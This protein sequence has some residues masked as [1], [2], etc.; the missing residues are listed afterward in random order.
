METLHKYVKDE[1]F[2][3]PESQWSL[4]MVID[5]IHNAANLDTDV[6]EN[7]KDVNSDDLL[8]IIA[9]FSFSDTHREVMSIQ[10]AM[11]L[12]AKEEIKSI[13]EDLDEPE[14]DEESDFER[15][16]EWERSELKS[17]NRGGV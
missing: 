13:I 14:E 16:Q 8:E 5:F 17:M 7:I 6:H 15:R 1:F 10:Q 11:I 4:A 12:N 9:D 3:L 2:E